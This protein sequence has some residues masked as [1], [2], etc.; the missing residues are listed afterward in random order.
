MTAESSA[1]WRPL[2]PILAV[3]FIGTLGFSIALPFLVFLV[4]DLGGAAWT[5]GLIGATYSA[6]QLVGAPVL[7]RWSDQV[8]RRRVLALSQAGTLVAWLVFLVALA[9]PKTSLGVVASATV[10]VPL[11]LLF[12]ARALD[13]LT[14]G[15]V[16]VANAYVADVTLEEP[17]LRAKAFGWMGMAASIGFSAG[18]ALGGVLALTSW[19]YAGP[20]G[21]AAV[22]SLIA[23]IMCLR[24]EEPE[25][26]CPTG[27]DPDPTVH[28]IMGQGQRR[29][30]RQVP[31]DRSNSLGRPI[32]VALLLATFAQFL[33]FNLFYAVF[34]VHAQGALNW[35]PST[36]G[37][38]FTVMAVAMILAEGPLLGL[39]SG[40][41]SAARVF[42]LG[43]ALL[44]CSFVVFTL[45]SL[46]LMF[47]AAIL[48]AV[49]NGLAWPTFQARIAEVA[50]P[51]S[52]G[53]VQGAATS[54][55]SAASILGLVAGAFLY[56]SLG[57][58][59]FLIGAALFA[60]VGL[61]SGVWFRGA[62][63]PK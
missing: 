58:H 38:L 9:L 37:G 45:E 53:A 12:A 36:M 32:V 60:V 54:A 6:F 33:A 18:P 10:T 35:T 34:P 23:T 30:D 62:T 56:S 63:A 50:G 25:R 15:N 51:E 16:S 13:G 55:G 7:G 57:T 41:L 42:G 22:I 40:R 5:Y 47:A 49:G 52:Q 27:P 24:L 14:G 48:F 59:L 39:V 4:A 20:V 8:G 21:L 26:P 46:E 3:Q 29:C 31:P 19:G 11:L 17:A 43:M 2:V 1:P 28:R 44:A 61:G